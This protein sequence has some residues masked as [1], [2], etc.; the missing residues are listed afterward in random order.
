VREYRLTVLSK[1]GYTGDNTFVFGDDTFVTVG[2][3]NEYLP[4][5]LTPPGNIG[6][7]RQLDNFNFQFEAYDAAFDRVAFAATVTEES[8]FDLDNIGFDTTE[9]DQG[10]QRLPEGLALN[11]LSGWMSGTA[12]A[13]SEARRVYTFKVTPYKLNRPSVT[14]QSITYTLTVLGSEFSTVTWTTNSDLGIIDEGRPCTLQLTA[15]SNVATN[16]VYSLEAGVAQQLP[17]G[18]RLTTDGYLIGRPTFRRFSVDADYTIIIV[19]STIGIEVDMDVTGSGAGT[20]AKVTEII[21]NNRLVVSPAIVSAAGTALTFVSPARTVI[22]VTTLPS[23]TT[24]IG[25][26]GLTTFDGIRQFT[27]RATASS[28]VYDI[29]VGDNVQTAFVMSQ[30]ESAASSV[31]V[32]VN[33]V[34]VVAILDYQ[35]NITTIIFGTAPAADARIIVIHNNSVSDTRTFSVRLAE[36]NLAPYENV[37]IKSFPPLEQRNQLKRLLDNPSL[38]PDSF[39]YRINDPWFGKTKDIRSLTL[40]GISPSSLSQYAAAMVQNHYNKN[41]R[42]GNIRTARAVDEFFN[43]KYEVVYIEL[44]DNQRDQGRSIG[45]EQ[46]DLS[47]LISNYF[48]DDPAFNYLYPNSFN[49]M[50]NRLGG[51]L[52]FTNR[53][54]LPDWM[55]SPQTDGKV[56]GFINAVVLAYTQPNKSATIKYRLEKS[57]FNFNSIDFT[58]DR[59][60]L[61]NSLSANFDVGVNKFRSSLETT[62]DYIPRVGE[63]VTTVNYA[64]TRT[65]YSINN[66]TVEYIN[67]TGGIDGIQGF[68]DGDTLIF[69]QQENYSGNSTPYDGWIVTQDSYQQEPFDSIGLDAYT[70]IPGW[71][72]KLTGFS[73]QNRRGGTWTVR[74]NNNTVT[75]EFTQEI[76]A[77]QQIRVGN[78]LTYGSSVVVYDPLV[79][80]G[81]SVPAYTNLTLNNNTSTQRTIFD[82]NGTKFINYRDIYAA[83]ESGD[84]YLK[85]PQIG[86]FN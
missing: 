72:S 9:F 69:A 27:V 68:Q 57:G 21:D 5:L 30:A 85:F 66:R 81:F 15:I 13:Q 32:T 36:Y 49:N 41:V 61:D 48:N 64:V 86:V 46:I 59:Y 65:F 53:G 11:Y 20:G 76:E 79:K 37:Y 38:F 56:I 7:V 34:S 83:P 3:D 73:T 63:I 82:G 2:Y 26:T 60:Q 35:V 43:T 58:A 17:Q 8:G 6:T 1:A 71:L 28:L 45:Q 44:V 22:L 54:A 84:K 51:V 52:G 62:F 14:G 24:T 39:I 19:S 4:I 74:I 16:V 67:S 23:Q 42:F 25:D 33:G 31:Y 47:K 78:G 10:E 75:L 80:S 12:A 77:G 40:P 70:V 18:V 29:F 55:T 50:S